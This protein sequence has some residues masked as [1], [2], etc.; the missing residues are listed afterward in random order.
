M[1][2]FGDFKINGNQL[3]AT[4]TGAAIPLTREFARDA[5]RI[6]SFVWLINGLRATRIVRRREPRAKI[7][8]FPKKPRSYYAIWP[9]CQLADVK[10][11]DDPDEADLHFYFE[12]REFLTAPRRSPTSKPAFN[13]GCFDIRKSVVSRIFEET[14]GYPL[15]VDPTKHDGPFV[16][17]SEFN[18][19]HDGRLISGPI[20][21]PRPGY[22]YQ[23]NIENT[24]DGVEHID[25][26]TP[27]VG[28][29]T[30]PLVFLKRRTRDLRFTN[31]NHRVDLAAIDAMLSGE[32]Q[33]R[34]C[35][36]AKAIRLD[37]GGLDILRDR[38]DGRIY[39]VDANKTDMGPPAAMTAQDK[40]T[41]MRSLASAFAGMVDASLQP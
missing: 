26:R 1:S 10:I 21:A 24:F 22:V 20:A 41:A 25:I 7:S 36:F 6:A 33:R 35:E 4:E 30:T 18:G 38:A 3:V 40:L 2:I 31:E 19:K 37:F 5:F 12:D 28:G 17:K 39:I 9:V 34:I 16:E 13:V 27:I 8:F 32:E 11:V 15:C 23:R 14:F 29:E